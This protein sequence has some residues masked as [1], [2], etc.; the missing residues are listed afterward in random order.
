MQHISIKKLVFT[1]MKDKKSCIDVVDE[2][3][4]CINA[5]DIS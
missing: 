1:Y 4:S 2:V 5:I 3:I